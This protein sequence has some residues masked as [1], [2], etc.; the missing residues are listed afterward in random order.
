MT[1]ESGTV[2]EPE[3]WKALSAKYASLA[4]ECLQ[5]RKQTNLHLDTISRQLTMGRFLPRSYPYLIAA[6]LV[7]VSLRI[8]DVWHRFSP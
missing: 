7:L 1:E 2:T 8:L 3:T 5:E 4:A 6:V